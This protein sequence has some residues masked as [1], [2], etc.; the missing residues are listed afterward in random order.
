MGF[1]LGVELFKSM[2]EVDIVHVA[3]KGSG[4]VVADL[5][6][7]NLQV[8]MENG[9]PLMPHVKAGKLKML[10]VTSAQRVKSFPDIPTIAESGYPDYVY[11]GML[12][13]YAPAKTPAEIVARLSQEIGA[14]VKSAAVQD[15]I[16]GQGCI[17]L[18]GT[19][20][21]LAS[22][23]QAESAKMAKLI[24]LTGVKLEL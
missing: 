19:P 16:V 3:Y 11:A 13:I 2:A 15:M 12:A 8:A 18:G 9:L 6:A 21:E 17:P 10:A 4:P 5:I 14:S 7:G 23:V 22:Y 20:F 24:K 1:F